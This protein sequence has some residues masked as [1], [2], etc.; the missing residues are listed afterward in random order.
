MSP[1]STS[2]RSRATSTGATALL[3]PLEERTETIEGR[4]RGRRRAA[5]P[6][7]RA[8]GPSS[9]ASRPTS[10]RSPRTLTPATDGV[11]AAAGRAAGGR[12][13]RQPGV[14]GAGA[15]HGGGIHL[16]AEPRSGLRRL[17]G[18]RRTVR[19]AR[20]EPRLR[21]RRRQHRL[22][23]ARQAP[24]PRRGRR[25]DAAAGVGLGLRM[26]GLHPVR[27]AA[28]LAQPRR[29]LHRHGQQRRSS[30]TRL[31]LLPHAGLGL[32][33]ARRAHRRPPPA[34]VARWASSPP[35]DMR[36]IQADNEFAM[37][38][39]LAAAYS[40]RRDRTAWPGCRARPAALVG[41]AEQRRLGCRRV[42][43]RAVG[44]ARRPTSS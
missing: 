1:T 2:R 38:K 7:H 19:R 35:H 34:Q 25:L 43:E 18:G 44:R 41:R 4:R 9:R 3:V 6:L 31:P 33:L 15:G 13:R 21:G 20:A 5:H 17:P 14:D 22:P 30:P 11:V 24:D 27:R 32:R 26:A 8:T 39:R 10:M 42:R 36:D 40:G 28:G 12:V 16:R 29:G 23:D 37:G